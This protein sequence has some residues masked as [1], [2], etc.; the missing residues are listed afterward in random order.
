M[1]HSLNI[2]VNGGG[3]SPLWV[4]PG[5][6][7]LSSIGKQVEETLKEASNRHPSLASAS[8]PTSRFLLFLSSCSDFLQEILNVEVRCLWGRGDDAG[9]K[10]Y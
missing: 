6:V 8:A 9:P 7:V 5:L 1:R 3:L 2:V 10:W 4:E